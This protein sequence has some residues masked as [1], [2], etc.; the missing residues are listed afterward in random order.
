MSD[1]RNGHISQGLSSPLCPPYR[2]N[3]FCCPLP[4]YGKHSWNPCPFSGMPHGAW[5]RPSHQRASWTSAA[6]SGSAEAE[7]VGAE[8]CS[9]LHLAPELPHRA[10]ELSFSWAPPPVCSFLYG[11]SGISQWRLFVSHWRWLH[12]SCQLQ[13]SWSLPPAAA[14]QRS[15]PPSLHA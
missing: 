9:L 7:A 12:P 14:S 6:V 13:S 3:M 1:R 10:A 2:L 15:N 8:A 4:H 11:H 5:R